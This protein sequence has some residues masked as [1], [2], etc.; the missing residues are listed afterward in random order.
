MDLAVLVYAAQT[1]DVLPEHLVV[2]PVIK[3]QLM[4]QFTQDCILNLFTTWAGY[5]PTSVYR[6]CKEHSIWFWCHAV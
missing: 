2:M 5:S 4:S 6:G 1:P 3:I